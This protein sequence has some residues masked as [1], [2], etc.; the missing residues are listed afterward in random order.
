MGKITTEIRYKEAS[1]N[2]VQEVKNLKMYIS[3]DQVFCIICN[4]EGDVLFELKADCGQNVGYLFEASDE[5][6]AY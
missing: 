4:Q 3:T 1:F 2:F 5:K 6:Y